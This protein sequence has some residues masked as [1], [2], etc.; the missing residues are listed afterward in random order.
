VNRTDLLRP[1]AKKL[2]KALAVLLD[3]LVIRVAAERVPQNLC[4][5][6]AIGRM[7]VARP[8]AIDIANPER[9]IEGANEAVAVDRAGSGERAV[10]IEE[11]LRSQ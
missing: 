11:S 2:E 10:D 8:V 7:L 3:F 9:I 6:P 1:F 4:G 5:E